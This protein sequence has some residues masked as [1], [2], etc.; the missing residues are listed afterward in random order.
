MQADP[1]RDDIE[2]RRQQTISS[3]QLDALASET[4]F[5]HVAELVADTFEVPIS[6]VTVLGT[7]RQLFHGSCGLD[8]QST[9]RADAFCNETVK[10]TSVL[11][12]EDALADPRFRDNPLVTGAPHIRFYAG[13]PLRIGED[14]SVGSLCIIDRQR[15][16]LGET[17]R[18]Q[19]VLLARTVSDLMELRLGSKLA[20]QRQ[21]ALTAQTDLL[22]AT[23]D[24]VQ[25]GIA[26]F[27]RRLHLL[28]WNNQL[29]EL[30]GLSPEFVVTGLAAADIVTDVSRRFSIGEGEP[31]EVLRELISS[32]AAANNSKRV[33][34]GEEDRA[35]LTWFA[36]VPD[37]RFIMT[38]ED[39][40]DRRRVERIKDEFVS[41][42]SHELR[43]PLTSIRG[44][45]A[46]LAKKAERS[47]DDQSSQLLRMA[48]KNAERLTTLINDI[49]DVEKLGS[50]AFSIKREPVDLAQ[51][52]DDVC[53][54]NR[55]F[56]LQHC[57]DLE[58]QVASRPL[59]VLGDYGRLSQVVANLVSNACKFSPPE[60]LVVVNL[61]DHG[62]KVELSVRDFGSGVPEAFASQIFDRFAQSDPAHRR[63]GSA[64]TG[65]GLAISKDIVEMHSGE[66]GYENPE[67][68]GARFWIRLRKLEEK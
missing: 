43:T 41:T 22:R 50:G 5:D 2:E 54:Q 45:L 1:K 17:E 65:L 27:D 58:L 62:D 37:G 31:D 49:L 11:V 68:G 18:R 29:I 51:L 10:E 21:L 44:A 12:V 55:A 67:G 14:V 7:E 52:A 15:R 33:L 48:N 39:V 66:I 9:A 13:A 40:S 28:L 23:V 42:V 59:F 32:V 19:L 20:H 16:T 8:Q 25:Q 63:T 3:Y 61:Q 38:V 24:S 35:L 56:A 57:K 34:I 6:A 53:E 36:S 64:G 60:S 4:E 46:I 47:L 30:L 26:V